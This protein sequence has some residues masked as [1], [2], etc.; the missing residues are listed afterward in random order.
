MQSIVAGD[1]REGATVK[2]KREEEGSNHRMRNC[3]PMMLLGLLQLVL[4]RSGLACESDHPMAC[5]PP[6]IACKHDPR[7][8]HHIQTLSQRESTNL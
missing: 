1:A 8:I 4:V 2:Y 6:L 3:G 5:A 7:N